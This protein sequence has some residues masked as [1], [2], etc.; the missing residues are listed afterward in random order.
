AGFA[1]ARI[2]GCRFAGA[3]LRWADF[4]GAVPG[5]LRIY[6]G[7]GSFSGRHQPTDFTGAVLDAAIF[8]DFD[9][10]SCLR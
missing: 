6:S 1:G 9:L 4:T 5:R 8:A 7:N 2:A 10:D 3:G